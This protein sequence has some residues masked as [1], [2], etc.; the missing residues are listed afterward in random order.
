MCIQRIVRSE[1]V[2]WARKEG[3]RIERG[4]SR[5][6]HAVLCDPPYGLEFM[7][8]EWDAPG[9]F[10]A[11]GIGDRPIEWPSFTQPFNGANPTCARCGGRARGKRRCACSEPEWIVKGKRL[12]SAGF[13][14]AGEEGKNDLKVKKNFSALPRFGGVPC[15]ENY[16]LWATEWAKALVPL[17]HP[18]ALV[19]CFGGT[20]TWHRLACGIEEAGFDVWDTLMWLHGQGFPKAQA[21]DKL[22]D[23]SLGTSAKR[24]RVAR[25][26]AAR[27][28][29]GHVVVCYGRDPHLWHTAPAHELAKP[30]SGHKTSAFKPAWEPILCFKAPNQGKTYAELALEHGSGALNV[31]GG[32]IPGLKG[33]GVWGTSNAGCSPTFNSSPMKHEFR[34]AEHASGRYPANLTLQC[35]CEEMEVVDAP[36]FG[37]VTG[38]EPTSV[39]PR[40]GVDYGE[41]STRPPFT[42][43]RGKAIRHTNPD[44]PAFMLDNQAGE[45]VSG[46]MRRE[47]QAYDGV[48]VTKMLRG[49]SGPSNQLGDG[50]GPSRFFYCAK[51]SR[52]E[53]EKG[54]HGLEDARR[55]TP[56]AGRGEPGLRCRA[57]GRWKVSG[58]PCKCRKPVF[59]QV[60]FNRPAVKND[61]P[62]V[63]PISLTT[64]LASLLLPP[65]SVSPRRLLI[66]FCGSGSEMIGALLAGWDDV[67]GIEQDPRYCRIARERLRWWKRTISRAPSG[68]R[69]PI[70]VSA[71]TPSRPVSSS[72]NR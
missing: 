36:V 39:R 49:R 6:Y 56:M 72:K 11:P 10:S 28:T 63:K 55:E 43:Y 33:D 2:A 54:L 14:Y 62:T 8:Q 9:K 7:G 20:R 23:K 25:N 59:E 51:A 53:R 22:T 58:N 3:K 34:S 61:H 17:L 41:F 42:A 37:D 24:I 65:E 67:V 31:D 5:P 57:C 35:A 27:A 48:S 44:C 4:E 60:T 64:W 52:A 45:T 47:V 40:K 38:K 70:L 15:L 26:P 21:I 69:E 13:G 19:F 50:G 18:G 1:F 66:P 46:A 32:R 29:R 16:Q 71:R 12:G 30:W 68:R